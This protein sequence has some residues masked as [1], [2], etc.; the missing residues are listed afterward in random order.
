MSAALRFAAAGWVLLCCAAQA[1]EAAN[2]PGA[3]SLIKAFI[4]ACVQAA[5]N[6]DRIEGTARF[7]GWKPLDNLEGTMFA[8]SNPNAK[9]KVW[10]VSGMADAPFFLAV[11]HGSESDETISVCTVVNPYVPS[12]PAAAALVRILHLGAPL[13]T[14]N[15]SGQVYTYWTSA[16]N[17]TDLLISLIDA[18][19]MG[20]AGVNLSV[21]VQGKQK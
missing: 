16:F 9:S 2:R 5:P 13:K 19:P 1:D 8:P 18:S 12:G 3:E 20:E 17:Q 10:L 11:T 21:A 4:G 15:E 6:F 14:E 7:F